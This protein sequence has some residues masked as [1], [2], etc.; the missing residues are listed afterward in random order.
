MNGRQVTVE[1][2]VNFERKIQSYGIINRFWGGWHDR[3][4]PSISQW[5]TI[6]ETTDRFILIQRVKREK[7]QPLSQVLYFSLCLTSI[8][9]LDRLKPMQ[10]YSI[11]SN[12]KEIKHHSQFEL[13]KIN[14]SRFIE[15]KFL[16]KTYPNSTTI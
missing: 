2:K 3:S 11:R 14:R 9:H 1:R 8:W 6:A 4:R 10:N 15:P 16:L 12:T 5:P 13:I 7:T